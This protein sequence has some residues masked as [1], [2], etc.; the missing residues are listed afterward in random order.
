MNPRQAFFECLHRSP[1]AL[2]EAALWIA[3]E[4][5]PAVDPQAILADFTVLQ[6]QVSLGMPLLPADELGQPLLR[7]MYDLGFAQDDFTPL[8]WTYLHNCIRDVAQEHI[9]TPP[10]SFTIPNIVTT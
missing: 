1:P 8:R 9:C 6:Q 7:I 2:F 3:A 10:L 4:H 5:D